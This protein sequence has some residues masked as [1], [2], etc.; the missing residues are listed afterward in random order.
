MFRA[1]RLR[2]LQLQIQNPKPLTPLCVRLRRHGQRREVLDRAEL[3]GPVV[4]HAGHI[5]DAARQQRVWNR[6]DAAPVLALLASVCQCDA[7]DC[8]RSSAPSTVDALS[9]VYQTCPRDSQANDATPVYL[10]FVF[11]RQLRAISFM[12]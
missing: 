12:Q 11:C 9:P 7:H 2:P 6:G 10:C 5:H 1:L 4:G 3:V 8:V